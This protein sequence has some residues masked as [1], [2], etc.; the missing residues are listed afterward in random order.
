MLI[1]SVVG[2][3]ARS[4]RRN[5]RRGKESEGRGERRTLLGEREFNV[6]KEEVGPRT[7]DE[8]SEQTREKEPDPPREERENHGGF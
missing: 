2:E 4:R 5:T 6:E 8:E 3:T 1:W 7:R